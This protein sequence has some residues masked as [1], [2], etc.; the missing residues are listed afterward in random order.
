MFGYNRLRVFD[1]DLDYNH[2]YFWAINL[3]YLFL[4]PSVLRGPFGTADQ[5][6]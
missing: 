1:S 5:N 6:R 4:F 2:F 3:G